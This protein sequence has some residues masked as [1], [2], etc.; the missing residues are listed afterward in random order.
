MTYEECREITTTAERLFYSCDHHNPDRFC[1]EEC[2]YA[3]LCNDKQLYWSRGVW[4]E[5]MG[6]D[7]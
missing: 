5:S 2:S 1:N 7:L 4:E 3:G 6:E